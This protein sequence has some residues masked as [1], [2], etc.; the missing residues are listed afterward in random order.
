[1]ETVFGIPL[2]YWLISSTLLPSF[3]ILV[4]YYAVRM[5][6]LESSTIEDSNERLNSS[7]LGS[8]KQQ[9]GSEAGDTPHESQ[10][11]RG[12]VDRR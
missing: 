10:S 6:Q 4:V 2:G 8:T 5:D 9:G 11:Q 7:D 12:Q 3:L 1:N